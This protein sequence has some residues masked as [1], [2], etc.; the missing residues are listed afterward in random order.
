MTIFISHSSHD[1]VFVNKLA[2]ELQVRGY[3][4]WVDHDDIPAGK[5]WA[6]VVQ[7]ALMES[8]VMLMVISQSALASYHVKV[9][10]QAFLDLQRPIFPVLLE[11]VD[12]PLLLR[13]FHNLDFSYASQFDE[14]LKRLM[15]AL[16]QPENIVEDDVEEHD[17]TVVLVAA[18]MKQMFELAEIRAQADR[19]VGAQGI[20]PQANTVTL[21]LPHVEQ[22]LYHALDRP[23]VI[24]RTYSRDDISPDIDLS[25]YDADNSISRRHAMIALADGKMRIV[26]LSSA[27]GTFL[28][29][30]RLKPKV[31]YEVRNNAIIR[32]SEKF[33]V[34]ILFG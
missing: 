18:K 17:T 8:Q 4:I 5:K 22:I 3:N 30:K 11:Q 28:E 26:D 32:L 24:G 23:L 25:Q 29:N 31:S 15:A 34:L 7:S 16:P 1:D 19:V 20:V 14:N 6:E 10:W 2:N 27:N 12:L 21:V 9:E 13:S 33:P